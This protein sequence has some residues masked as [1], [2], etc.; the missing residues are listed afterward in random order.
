MLIL[1]KLKCRRCD[2]LRHVRE[3][4][5]NIFFRTCIQ[6]RARRSHYCLTL[7]VVPILPTSRGNFKPFLATLP[8]L[9][10]AATIFLGTDET[11]PLLDFPVLHSRYVSAS[12]PHHIRLHIIELGSAV[13][14]G[15]IKPANGFLRSQEHTVVFLIDRLSQVRDVTETVSCI[16]HRARNTLGSYPLNLIFLIVLKGANQVDAL[17]DGANGCDFVVDFHGAMRSSLVCVLA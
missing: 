13:I 7:S 6:V 2:V 1:F 15:L 17:L 5:N 16:A 11:L 4:L 3:R 12:L 9:F 8:N 14:C 10:T